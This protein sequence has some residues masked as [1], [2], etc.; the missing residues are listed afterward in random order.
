[1]IVLAVVVEF[2]MTARIFLTLLFASTLA[3]YGDPPT[4][5]ETLAPDAIVV[6]AGLSGLSAAIEMGRAGVQ[7]LVVDMNSVAG[8]HAV[9]AGGVALVGTPVQEEAGVKD[10]PELAYRDWM[11]WTGDGDPVW[12]RYYAENSRSMIYDWVTAMG[13]EFVRAGAANGNSVP[14]FHFTRGRALHLVMPMFKTALALPNVSLVWN[15]RAERLVVENGAVRGVVI[16]HLRTGRTEALRATN[17]VLATGGFETDLDR[18]LGNWTPGLPRPDRLLAGSAI[19]AT[20][21]GHDMA[22]DAG[23]VLTQIDRHY[24]YIDGLPDPRDPEGIHALTGGNGR[25][26][27]VNAQGR[28]FTNES[29]WDKQI[30]VDLLNQEPSTYWAVFDETA[31][32]A[33]GVRGAAWLSTPMEG[34]PILDNPKSAHKA[35]SLDA[36]A[37]MAG[38]PADALKASV[39][40]FNSLIA[41]GADADFKR[42]K[43]GDRLPATIAKPPFY[44]VQFFPMTRKNMGGVSIDMGARVL[45]R[46]GQVVRGLYAAGELTGSVGIN[47]S[48]GMDGMFL[49]PA[50]LTGRLA[51]RSIAQA[52]A[53]ANATPT[54][55]RT[56]PEPAPQRTFNP[57]LTAEFLK[58]LLPSAR[59]GP[60]A[61]LRA[62]YWHFEQVHATVV[63]RAYECTRCHS[64]ELPFAPVVTRQQHEA[65]IEL[66]VNCH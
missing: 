42:F 27:W 62:G 28:R 33:F 46:Q 24:I 23:A 31:R 30:L 65:Q 35:G 9:L 32:D 57:A 3:V 20:G 40:R 4:A 21:S 45:N 17:T 60:S 50:I 5:Q 38:L 18:V 56:A 26:M 6:G 29:G 34:H 49:G 53:A 43:A 14:R 48:H 25:A 61:T 7:V 36:L 52:H 41:S 2:L 47:G 51:G 59:S 10:S 12:T 22:A 55:A 19:S 63:E 1:V 11:E 39:A 54:P 64:P 15:A 16:R 13:V 58:P 8:G 37:A 44:A 66:C